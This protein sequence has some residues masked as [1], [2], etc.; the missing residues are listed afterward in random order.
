MGRDTMGEQISNESTTENVEAFTF[1]FD[2]DDLISCDWWDYQ[3]HDYFRIPMRICGIGLTE[4]CTFFVNEY[5]KDRK[6][7]HKYLADIDDYH[8]FMNVLFEITGWIDEHSFIITENN[9]KSVKK[10]INLFGEIIDTLKN[11]GEIPKDYKLPFELSDSDS[12]GSD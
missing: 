12:K 3:T 7:I 8:L 11:I 5:D 10:R 2:E 6:L 9:L 4:T 1:L